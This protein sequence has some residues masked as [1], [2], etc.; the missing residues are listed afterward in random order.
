MHCVS[1]MTTRTAWTRYMSGVTKGD[2]AEQVG[3]GAQNSFAEIFY[4]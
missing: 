2:R 4:D 1:G 3:E